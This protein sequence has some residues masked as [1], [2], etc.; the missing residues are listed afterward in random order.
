[1][2][3]IRF[4]AFHSR[5]DDHRCMATETGCFSGETQ[6]DLILRS[7]SIGSSWSSLIVF[8]V[9]LCVCFRVDDCAEVSSETGGKKVQVTVSAEISTL[10]RVIVVVWQMW[11]SLIRPFTHQTRPAISSNGLD[12]FA[13]EVKSIKSMSPSLMDRYLMEK[14][15]CRSL[16]KY[17]CLCVCE[18]MCV[19]VCVWGKTKKIVGIK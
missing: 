17:V 2:L 1:M 3:I 12:P 18:S 4:P 5:M 19:S 7:T 9:D 15:V 11:F 16:C 14:G 13:V 10:R 8:W 6:F